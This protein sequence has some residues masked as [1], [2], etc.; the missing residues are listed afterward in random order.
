MEETMTHYRVTAT[1]WNATL[2]LYIGNPVKCKEEFDEKYDFDAGD[3]KDCRGFFFHTQKKSGATSYVIWLWRF[4]K[5]NPEDI[6]VLAHEVAHAV[7]TIL[8]H[9]QLHYGTKTDEAYAHLIEFFVRRFLLKLA[10]KK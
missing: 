5:N 2:H 10:R 9:R 4:R 6:S 8:R 1:Q 7:L 3:M